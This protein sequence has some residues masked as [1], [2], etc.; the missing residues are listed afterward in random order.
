MG[1]LIFGKCDLYKTFPAEKVT[2]HKGDLFNLKGLLKLN[3]NSPSLNLKSPI[4]KTF[5]FLKV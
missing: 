1:P 4:S 2:Y 5:K 3:F